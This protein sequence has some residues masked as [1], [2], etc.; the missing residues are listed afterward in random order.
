MASTSYHYLVK[1]MRRLISD[2]HKKKFLN[3]KQL[4]IIFLLWNSFKL[5][6]ISSDPIIQLLNALLCIGIF[7]DIEDRNQFFDIRKKINFTTFVGLVLFLITIIRS[8]TLTN[9]EDKY[10]YFLLPI[11][12]ISISFI[13]NNYL[14]NKF[15]RNI[16][17]ISLLLPLRR[18]FFFLANPILLFITKYLTWLLL[19]CLGAEPNLIGRSILIGR[20][21]LVISDGCG[22]ADNLYFAINAVVIYA[23]IFSLKKN[24]NQLFIFLITIIIPIMTNVI[25]NTSLALIINLD[26]NIRDKMFTFFHD[27]YGSLIFSLIS[28]SIISYFYFNLL[29]KEL[30]LR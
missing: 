25:R 26:I 1:R 30:N 2:I 14:G 20:S 15:F 12:I 9:V 24:I 4:I 23:I 29:N 28:L 13:G 6:Q 5:F 7:F 18:I 10:Y 19:F 8:F 11:G 21:E 27:S 3:F 22:G 16:I 17:F